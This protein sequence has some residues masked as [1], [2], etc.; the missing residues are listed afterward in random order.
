MGET[1]LWWLAIQ[2]LGLAALPIAA[3]L[4]RGV[5]DRGYTAAKALGLLL[6]T[7]LAFTISMAG[8]VPFG[9]ALL[10]ACLLLVAALSA[11]LLLRD[12]KALLWELRAQFR[13]R[14]FL[15]H[16]IAAEVLFALLFA[17]WAWLRAYN[18]EILDQEKF[19][20]YGI[21]NSI[22][23]TGSVPPPDMWLTGFSLNY[24][25]F[26]YILMAAMSSLSGVAASLSFNIANAFLFAMT[27]LGGYGVVYNLIVGT[28]LRRAGRT[29][30]APA[31]TPPPPAPAPSRPSG[32]RGSKPAPPANNPLPTRQAR[33]QQLAF[34]G[35]APGTYSTVVEEEVAAAPIPARRSR[36]AQPEEWRGVGPVEAGEGSD[37]PTRRLPLYLSP[38]LYGV[39]AALMIVAMGNLAVPFGKKD[40]PGGT[41]N[42]NGWR[43]CFFCEKQGYGYWWDPS[44]IIMDYRTVQQPDG[45]LLKSAVEPDTINEFPAFSFVLADMHPHIMGLPFVLLAVSVAYALGRRRAARSNR[46]ARSTPSTPGTILHTCS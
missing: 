9:R 37:D 10:F 38:I 28:L 26:G 32:R 45:T 35:A 46:W 4:M 44:R 21:L 8:A 3:V 27:G 7:W 36:A 43:F 34:A 18:P 6:V 19:M 15:R 14:S 11:W 33:F 12:N 41:A 16:L 40:A 22:L 42:A 20:D 31:P 25:Y 17:V 29:A 30:T 39:L 24:Y 5:P 13:T 2:V 23:R 1:F